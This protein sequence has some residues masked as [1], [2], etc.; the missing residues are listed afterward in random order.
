MCPVAVAVNRGSTVNPATG[1]LETV[2]FKKVRMVKIDP[3]A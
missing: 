3:R 1:V 2:L